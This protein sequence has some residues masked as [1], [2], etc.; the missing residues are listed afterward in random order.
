MTLEAAPLSGIDAITDE[1]LEALLLS[2]LDALDVSRSQQMTQLEGPV[3][4]VSCPYLDPEPLGVHYKYAALHSF[5][6]R[7]FL[8]DVS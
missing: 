4:Q 6:R 2:R 3:L 8:H 1:Y 7:D 5:D